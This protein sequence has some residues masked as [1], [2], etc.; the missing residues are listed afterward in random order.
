M[1][2]R[3]LHRSRCLCSMWAKSAVFKELHLLGMNVEEFNHRQES[4]QFQKRHRLLLTGH[5]A[6]RNKNWCWALH[7]CNSS[8]LKLGPHFSVQSRWM[9]PLLSESKRKSHSTI[10]TPS[11]NRALLLSAI[12]KHL[13]WTSEWNI[14]CLDFTHQARCMEEKL[15]LFHLSQT[16]RAR[17]CQIH[18]SAHQSCICS[19]LRLRVQSV[20]NYFSPKLSC[21]SRLS[22]IQDAH[23]REGWSLMEMETV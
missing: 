23:C 3:L 11:S 13:L 5:W 4:P 22:E 7:R 15:C 8:I 21:K 14:D 16:W 2:Q 10:A 12:L 20:H 9:R 19:C 17:L 18:N 1:R 6:H